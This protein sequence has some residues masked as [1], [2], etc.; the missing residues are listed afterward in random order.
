[1]L[2]YTE[3]LDP[4]QKSRLVTAF[5]CL[6]HVSGTA[7]SWI[8][9]A[10]KPVGT[11]GLTPYLSLFW[12]HPWPYYKNQDP[13]EDLYSHLC[14]LTVLVLKRA[15]AVR[16][17]ISFL[18]VRIDYANHNFFPRKGVYDLIGCT[19]N[20][21]EILQQALKTDTFMLHRN[22]YNHNPWHKTVT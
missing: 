12:H 19:N 13:K 16:K 11:H 8:P 5:S 21:L 18:H 22:F 6:Y 15:S 3:Q 10:T 1:M 9:H 20:F 2:N 14:T 17:I 7:C 4:Q